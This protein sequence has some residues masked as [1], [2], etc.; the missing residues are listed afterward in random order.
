M[1][2]SAIVRVEA[3]TPV[4]DVAGVQ[5]VQ[6][7]RDVQC[8]GLALAAPLEQPHLVIY[9]RLLQV[10]ALHTT[11]HK[12]AARSKCESTVRRV[13]ARATHDG[14]PYSIGCTG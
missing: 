14:S 2:C 13:V 3:G 4:D 5:E 9:Q 11:N 12:V 10:P 8:D 1:I 6:A 7:A